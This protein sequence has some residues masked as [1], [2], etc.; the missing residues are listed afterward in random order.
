MSQEG[1]NP[2]ISIGEEKVAPGP[3]RRD[4]VPLYHC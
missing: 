2:V 3:I 1:Q 4:L